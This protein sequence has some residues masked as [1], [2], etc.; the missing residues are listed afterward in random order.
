M[1]KTKKI[2][3]LFAF[4]LVF[5]IAL[6]ACGKGGDEQSMTD[7]TVYFTVVFDSNGGGKVPS[8]T[9]ESGSTANRPASPSLNGM[10][11]ED[12]YYLGAPWDFSSPVNSDVTLTAKWLDPSV[13]HRVA[14]GVE[15]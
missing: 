2:L 11:F 12:W 5:V 6:S 14:V 9:V 4:M 7:K 13:K 1:K 15:R 8:Q 3:I 10:V